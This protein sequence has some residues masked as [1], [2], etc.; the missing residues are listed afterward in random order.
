MREVVK[1]TSHNLYDME[2]SEE[3]QNTKHSELKGETKK[4]IPFTIA[5]AKKEGT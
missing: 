5:T 1:L 2:T 3:R 4:T